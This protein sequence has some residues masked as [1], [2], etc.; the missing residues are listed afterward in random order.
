MAAGIKKWRLAERRDNNRCWH[1]DPVTDL[2][3]VSA[4]TDPNNSS[5]EELAAFLKVPGLL[6]A[7]VCSPTVHGPQRYYN[8]F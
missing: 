3:W 8:C 5:D 2:T 4:G 7:R 6:G 1:K